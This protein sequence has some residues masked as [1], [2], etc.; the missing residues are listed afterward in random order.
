[1]FDSLYYIRTPL[2]IIFLIAAMWLVG[3]FW[4]VYDLRM[5]YYGARCPR[6]Y[7]YPYLASF[8]KP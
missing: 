4:P 7:R 8:C 3:S 6:L 2:I 5:S 1:M